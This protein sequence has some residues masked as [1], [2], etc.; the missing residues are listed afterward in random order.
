MNQKLSQTSEL[1]TELNRHQSD[2]T[3]L[4]ERKFVKLS[5]ES[6][7]PFGVLDGILR[8]LAQGFASHVLVPVLC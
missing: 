2:L 8:R 3:A 6:Q 1:K 7:N 5:I 4:G